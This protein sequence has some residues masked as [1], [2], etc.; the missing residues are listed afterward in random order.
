MKRFLA[1]LAVLVFLGLPFAGAEEINAPETFKAQYANQTGKSLAIVDAIVVVPDT[2]IFAQVEVF[3]YRHTTEDAWRLARAAMPE[4]DWARYSADGIAAYDDVPLYT[5][6]SDEMEVSAYSTPPNISQGVQLYCFPDKAGDVVF[7]DMNPNHRYYSVSISLWDYDTPFGR[8]NIM[9]TLAFREQRGYNLPTFSHSA[10][11]I[12]W[13]LPLNADKIEG[14]TLTL[15]QAQA[16]AES[17]VLKAA[18][19]FV[20]YAY[21]QEIGHVSL[22]EAGT[23]KYISRNSKINAYGFIFSRSVNGA[24]VTILNGQMQ[25]ANGTKDYIASPTPGYEQIYVTVDGDKIHSFD[26]DYAYQTGE[27]LAEDS[28]LLS[29]AEIMDIFGAV[30]PLSIASLE[31]QGNNKMTIHEIRLGYMPV[32]L[33][34]RPEIW[35]LRPVW[36]FFGSQTFGYHGNDY[37]GLTLLTIDAIDG[38]V[39]DRDLG[40]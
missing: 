15:A 8:H 39:I 40:Y 29:F 19:G 22:H 10:A 3:P 25:S 31:S 2:E 37:P 35:A 14:Q 26:W 5:G 38:T 32:R 27:T 23:D 16:L 24:P 34:D 21:G 36:D 1:V 30:A 20:L 33:K 12:M 9:R 17:L 11:P 6:D 28:T 18:E 4:G 13:L 7:D